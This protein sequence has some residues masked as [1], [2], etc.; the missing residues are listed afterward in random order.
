MLQ[1]QT[2]V[3]GSDDKDQK[4]EVTAS[5]LATAAEDAPPPVTVQV[6][7]QAAESEVSCRR[8][9]PCAVTALAYGVDARIK[10]SSRIAHLIYMIEFGC[11]QG[12]GRL[13]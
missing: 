2:P 11:A 7:K 9:A 12:V 13:G 10:H 5:P 3:S 6:T 1:A 8:Q 4:K